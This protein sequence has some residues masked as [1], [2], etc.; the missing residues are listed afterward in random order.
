MSLQALTVSMLLNIEENKKTVGI[1]QKL[2]PASLCRFSPLSNMLQIQANSST[3]R[4]SAFQKAARL[5]ADVI[6]IDGV[7]NEEIPYYKTRREIG[8]DIFISRDV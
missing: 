6:I 4:A 8:F 7:S 3:E 1:F 2:I 5:D